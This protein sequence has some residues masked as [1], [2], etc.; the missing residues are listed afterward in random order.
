MNALRRVLV[1]SRV[2]ALLPLVLVS[3]CDTDAPTAPVLRGAEA[4]AI[5]GPDP[6]VRSTV[7][8]ASPRDTS[9]AVQVLGSGF[10]RGTQAVWGLHG[11]TTV[12]TTKVHVGSTTFVSPHELIAEIT[13]DADATLDRYDVLAVT[14]K[15]KKGI[16]IELFAVTINMT[17]LPSLSDQGAG[18]TAINDAGTVAGAAWANDRPYAVRW[19]KRGRIW[20]IEKLPANTNDGLVAVPWDIAQDGTIV[21][22]RFRLNVEDQAPRATVW[23]IS[24]GIV[25]LGPG[26]ALGA[27]AEGTIVGS[28]FEPNSG[29]QGIQAVVWT[30]TAGRTWAPGQLLPR[31][32]NGHATEALGVN[33]AGTVIAGDAWDS[34]DVEYAVKWTLVGGQWR[35]PIRLDP[36]GETFA[37]LVNASGDI[38]GGGFP[39]GDRGACQVQAMFWP[40]R[41]ARVDVGTLG[42]FLSVN[43]PIGLSNSGEVVG[44]AFTPEF[45]EYAYLWRPTSASIVN[46]GHLIGDESSIATD[47]NGHHQ[48]V[49]NSSGPG[50]AHAIV[51][52]PR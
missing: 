28:R 1:L 9:I 52:T 13:I 14:S 21:G 12:A 43:T 26:S 23:P 33:P 39:C 20:A 34:D 17:A 32:P 22:V 45:A 27:N 4:A 29:P 40:A 25:D 50:G 2:A 37:T 15:G 46:L 8:S 30:R 35:G 24:G 44:L 31:L 3:D 36:V 47:I 48:V 42:V 49:G 5:G 10:D 6:A 41:G 51:W 16:G 38:A 18:A 11:D 19:T 7:P